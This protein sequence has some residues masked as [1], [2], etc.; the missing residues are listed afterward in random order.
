VRH[1]VREHHLPAEPPQ[2]GEVRRV[3]DDAVADGVEA[4]AEVGKL[5]RGHRGDARQVGAAV[6]HPVELGV[7]LGHQD[8][9]GPRPRGLP[10]GVDAGHGGVDHLADLRQQLARTGVPEHQGAL[11]A[12]RDDRPEVPEPPGAALVHRVEVVVPREQP[13]VAGLGEGQPLRGVGGL[14]VEALDRVPQQHVGRPPALGAVAGVEHVVDRALLPRVEL[15]LPGRERDLRQRVEHRRLPLHEGGRRGQHGREE[16]LPVSAQDG[17]GPLVEQGAHRP[18]ALDPGIGCGGGQHRRRRRGGRHGGRRRRGAVAHDRDAD[19]GGDQLQDGGGRDTRTDV[20]D[21]RLRPV[22]PSVTGSMLRRQRRPGCQSSSDCGPA[23]REGGVVDSR[24]SAQAGTLARC[25]GSSCGAGTTRSWGGPSGG[26]GCRSAGGGGEVA[27]FV[28]SGP[29]L[30]GTARFAA[31]AALVRVGPAFV[32]V[33]AAAVVAGAALLAGA[34]LVRAGEAAAAV[35][36]TV[37]EGGRAVTVVPAA[38]AGRVAPAGRATAAARGVRAGALG[39]TGAGARR[40]EVPAAGSGAWATAGTLDVAALRLPALRRGA[41]RTADTT[42]LVGLASDVG[43]STYPSTAEEASMAVRSREAGSYRQVERFLRPRT[44]NAAETS[45]VP[46]SSR[47]AVHSTSAGS[48]PASTRC[49][50]TA[51]P[52]DTARRRGGPG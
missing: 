9:D 4:V 49:S 3:D 16:G 24:T 17:G 28:G 18:F 7:V 42:L 19:G 35:G 27:S 37:V 31:G 34:A 36:R 44:L 46:L 12:V 29:L 52:S 45:Q 26:A 33:G 41:G 38:G 25:R 50:V 21:A 14:G 1:L 2:L 30:A 10:D 48:T 51:S 47:R 20:D 22:R 13:V 15:V 8:D 39:R 40:R 11:A 32:L 6:E 43:G 23:G 5:G